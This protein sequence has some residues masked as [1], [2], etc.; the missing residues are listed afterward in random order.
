MRSAGLPIVLLVFL[1]GAY[2]GYLFRGT[3][4]E[5]YEIHPFVA[6]EYPGMFIFDRDSDRLYKVVYNGNVSAVEGWPP[7]D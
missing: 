3:E 2:A 4:Q 5:R 7:K 1:I 6:G